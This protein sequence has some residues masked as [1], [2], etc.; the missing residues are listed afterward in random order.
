[1]SASGK[2]RRSASGGLTLLLLLLLIPLAAFAAPARDGKVLF[3]E[4]FRNLDRWRPL[5]FPKIPRHSTYV[6]QTQGSDH[7]LKA[8]SD[9]SA[10]ALVYGENF[11]IH[12]Y[13]RARWRWRVDN[14]YRNTDPETK[15]GDD[16]PIRIYITFQ[17]DPQKA[18]LLDRIIYGAARQL[19]GEYPPHSTLAYVWASSAGQATILASPYTDKARMIALK[20]GSEKAGTWQEER[21]DILADYRRAFGAEPPAVASIAI[22]NDSDDSGQKSVSY[23]DFIEVYRD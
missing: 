2:Y 16:Y 12:D 8:A 10:S 11:S 9:A 7:Y 19:Y 17:Y 20:K 23:I 13:P 1:M 14:V 4:D 3:R 15:S 5:H 6:I 22:M 18:S 21:V